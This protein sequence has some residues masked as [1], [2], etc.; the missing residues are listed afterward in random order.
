MSTA[1]SFAAFD[2]WHYYLTIYNLLLQ[3]RGKNSY[4]P[5]CLRKE[6]WGMWLTLLLI[7]V[8]FDVPSYVVLWVKKRVVPYDES[9]SLVENRVPLS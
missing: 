1:V 2:I 8:V 7:F 3:K 4:P 6:P 9:V 5:P